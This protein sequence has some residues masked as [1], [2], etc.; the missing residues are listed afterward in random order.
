MN[1]TY[2]IGAA[3]D[4]D[5]VIDR[6]NLSGHHARLSQVGRAY[7]LE[8]LGSTNGTY[9]DGVRVKTC[10]V[11]PSSRIGFGS[12]QTD[13][14]TLLRAAQ[15][16]PTPQPI[17]AGSFPEQAAPE[18]APAATPSV[19]V[20][21]VGRDMLIL[22]RDPECDVSIADSR[23]SGRHARVFRNCG[24]IIIE[25]IGSANGTFLNGERISW[26]V[27]RPEDVVQIGSRAFRFERECDPSAQT[28]SGARVDLRDVCIDVVDNAT[29]QP[30]RIIHNISITALPGEIVGVMGPSGSGKTTL[31]WALAGISV[32]TGG[33][34]LVDGQ[35]L[36]SAAGTIRKEFAPLV[37]FA[38]QDDIVHELLTVEEAVRYSARLRCPTTISALEIEQRVTRAI[39]NVGL[40]H[41][42]RTRIGSATT[43]SL[44][45]GQRKRVSIAMELVTDPPLL[46][47]DEPTSGLSSRDAADLMGMLRRLAD[48]GRTVILT[49]HQPSYP[50]FVQMDQVVLLDAGRLAYFGPS[51]IDI[52]EFFDVRERQ[53]GAVFDRLAEAEGKGMSPAWPQ[54]YVGS[55]LFLR[56]VQGRAQSL[57]SFTPPDRIPPKL[58]GG[59]STLVLLVR[60]GLL[61][62]AR[63]K[64]F[65]VVAI[66]VPLLASFL[67]TMVIRTQLDADEPWS[68][69]RAGV[70]HTYLVVLTIMVCFFGS[71]STSLEILY[72]RAVFGRERRS[73]LGVM[74]YVGSKAVMYLIP[75]VLHPAMSLAAFLLLGDALEGDFLS[76]YLV[77]VPGFF[78]AAAAGLCLS[79]VMRSAEGV[80]GFAVAYSIVQT[81]FSAFAPLHVSQGDDAQH[82][83]LEWVA[84][85]VTGR[86][87]L[88]GLVAQSDLCVEGDEAD[89]EKDSP[90]GDK[91]NAT[92]D[93]P[94]V[95]PPP[96]T[97]PTG[98]PEP[99]AAPN[100]TKDCRRS[101]YEDHGVYPSESSSDR[102][103]REYSYRS[104]VANSILSLIALIATGLILRR[105][106]G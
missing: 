92:T 37:G 34:I 81:V 5:I 7:V 51:A 66:I 9:I 86:W 30:L 103:K 27:L 58:R 69:L 14:E 91:P 80:V 33:D 12:Y 61:M 46:L 44:S 77:L 71:L 56:S 28:V 32:P 88:N 23:V 11:T 45:G 59:L 8:D 64:F 42:R 93:S 4:C 1:R 70:E 15:Y 99:P 102:V 62:K 19:E 67:I 85:P 74:P 6:A 68:F 79:A 106:R 49:I 76:Y 16:R 54:R 29:G 25:D 104:V 95:A 82:K 21:K 57:S 10:A 105:R 65:W 52:F 60:R 17:G 26:W 13:L 36:H 83:W 40:S 96:A 101:Y 94:A 22:G 35:Q 38:P 78:A 20:V 75:S 63:D 89:T 43:K 3:P 47:L 100:P 31:L 90:E 98:A 73:G 18:V 53:A 39:D 72:E 55:K 41:K 2:T 48:E 50:M 87:T 24:R 84:T 97:Q